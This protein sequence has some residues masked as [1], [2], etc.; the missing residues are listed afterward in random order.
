MVVLNSLKVG[1]LPMALRLREVMSSSIH[2]N[3][4]YCV[5]NRFISDNVTLIRDILE[6]SSS[7]ATQTGLIFIDQGTAFDPAEQQYL[8]Q[9]LVALRF[10]FMVHGFISL[11]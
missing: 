6:L 3:Q 11:M 8:W 5:P 9:T 1:R 2:P 7:L 10:N 4:T